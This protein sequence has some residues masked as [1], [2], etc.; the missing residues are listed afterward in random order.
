MNFDKRLHDHSDRGPGI[1]LCLQKV[2]TGE[3]DSAKIRIHHGFSSEC[4]TN[5]TQTRK[6]FTQSPAAYNISLKIIDGR[7]E[8][9]KLAKATKREKRGKEDG[10][11]IREMELKKKKKEKKG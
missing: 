10:F 11:M 7:R 3:R 8:A 6:K 9:E 4:V 5:T 2:I 1:R